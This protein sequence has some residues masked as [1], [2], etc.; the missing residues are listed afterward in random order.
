MN[1]G[2]YVATFILAPF[3]LFSGLAGNLM[4]FFILFRRQLNKIGP[5]NIYRLLFITDTI[6]L[7]SIAPK[8]LEFGFGIHFDN[9]SSFWCK[10]NRYF[11]YAFDAISPMLRVVSFSYFFRFIF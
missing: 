10:F 4:G 2:Y 9:V 5:I 8:Y 6:Y 7:M 11:D 1:A 3:I